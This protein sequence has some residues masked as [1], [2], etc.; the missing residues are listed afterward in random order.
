MQLNKM[1]AVAR[2]L[3]VSHGVVETLTNV[4]WSEGIRF[5][6]NDYLCT[7]GGVKTQWIV[8]PRKSTSA[9]GVNYTRER[10]N[11]RIILR[12]PWHDS[13]QLR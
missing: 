5:S 11:V 2:G 6:P 3:L 10:I 12:C 1:V 8:Q 13:W 7:E 4:V 9:L